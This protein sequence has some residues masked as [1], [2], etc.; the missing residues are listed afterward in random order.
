MVFILLAAERFFR[1][2]NAVLANAPSRSGAI[3]SGMMLMQKAVTLKKNSDF[4]RLY[5]RGRSAVDAAV[6]VYYAKNKRGLNR[7]GITTGKKIGCAVQRNRAKR[8]IRE[9]YRALEPRISRGWDF[10]FVA[11]GRTPRLKSA[12]LERAM[13]GIFRNAGILQR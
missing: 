5:K 13:G 7:I 9:A 2:Q 1:R 8:I 4:R 10:V 6:V 3:F 12:D 11:R